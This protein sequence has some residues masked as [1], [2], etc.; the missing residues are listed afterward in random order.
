VTTT[1]HE[2]DAHYSLCIDLFLELYRRRGLDLYIRLCHDG[3]LYYLDRL[4]GL[5]Y[6]RDRCLVRCLQKLVLIARRTEVR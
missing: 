2:S 4:Y 6:D 1:C 5:D 3:Y